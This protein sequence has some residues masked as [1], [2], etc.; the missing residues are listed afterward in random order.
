MIERDDVESVG[1]FQEGGRP[2]PAGLV[3]AWDV[4][5]ARYRDLV[6]GRFLS[7]RTIH[8]YVERSTQASRAVVQYVTHQYA[9]G[10]LTAQQWAR[11]LWQEIKTEHI[12]QY[13]LGIGGVNQMDAS[14]WGRV[15]G[16]LSDQW[17]YFK[18]FVQELPGLSE[19][20][21]ASRAQMYVSAAREAYE[22]ANAIAQREAG[23]EE[24]LWVLGVAEHCDDCVAFAEMGW[25]PLG[26]FPMP[27]AGGT[28]CLTNCKCHKEYRKGGH[29][30]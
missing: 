22:R 17:R 28:Q 21:I 30:G 9:E 2:R 29:E 8:D 16:I 5:V 14:H 1:G 3:W 7:Y 13:L 12:R 11:A 18:D 23:M 20:Q 10:V 27:G 4:R 24:E 19:K 15:G 25:Q 26:Y 6:T